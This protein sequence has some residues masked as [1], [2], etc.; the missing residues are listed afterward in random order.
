MTDAPRHDHTNTRSDEQNRRERGIRHA[1][2]DQPEQQPS[3]LG[4]PRRHGRHG[5]RWPPPPW[6]RPRGRRHDRANA[7]AGPPGSV[8]ALSGSSMEVQ[9]ASTG[10]TT[11]NWTPSTDVLQDGD[12]GG[13]RAGRRRLRH[14]ERD[15][16]K[17][18]KTT[19]AARTITVTHAARRGRAPASVAR[20]A[21]GGGAG[22]R[23]AG[24][25]FPVRRRWRPARGRRRRGRDASEL[26]RRW[27]VAT[28][29]R[30]WP[31]WPSR[32]ARSP[33]SAARPSRC[34]ASASA[35]AASPVARA[36]S[37]SQ[38]HEEARD[39]QDRNAQGHDLELDHGQCHP[40][41]RVDGPRRR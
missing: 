22:A 38:E 2:T 31:T 20:G 21:A 18:S 1:V 6:P 35:R 29:A 11:V 25:G 12:R 14:R 41:G 13:Q 33:P 32:R 8:A 39:A 9:N 40:D 26:Q 23:G 27:I 28:S 37:S 24:G 17:K 30:H 3:A 4:A 36:K 15:A 16:S 19:I 10:Q 5:A 34:R 7:R